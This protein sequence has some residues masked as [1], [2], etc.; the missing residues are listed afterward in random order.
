[1]SGTKKS[2]NDDG[3]TC[4]TGDDDEHDTSET[5]DTGD[6]KKGCMGIRS[7]RRARVGS[8]P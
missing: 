6:Y 3:A 1:M 5:G 8:K 7:V 4:N 2:E